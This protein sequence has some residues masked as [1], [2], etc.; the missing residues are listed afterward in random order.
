M[1][2][3]VSLFFTQVIFLSAMFAQVSYGTYQVAYC[4]TIL[5]DSTYQ[6]DQFGY[7]GPAPLF[8]HIWY[9]TKA[10]ADTAYLSIG[11]FTNKALPEGL[12]GVYEQLK[13]KED[14]I[15]IRDAIESD[16]LTGETNDFGDYTHAD[17][18]SLV[19]KLKTQSVQGETPVRLDFPA[20]VYHH[21]S[22]GISYENYTM[23]EFFASHGFVFISANF[24]LPYEGIQYGLQPYAIY[25]KCRTT[26]GG[27]R[28]VMRF[29]KDLC[30]DQKT[31]LI[32]H[33]WGA[34]EGWRLL[35]DDKLAD[36]FVSLETT[37]EYKQDT[38]QIKE[39]WPE[40]YHALDDKNKSMQIPVLVL[41]AK[42]EGLSFNVFRQTC[43]NH[44]TFASY[45]KPFD[46]NSYAAIYTNRY[47]LGNQIEMTDSSYLKAQLYGYDRHLELIL[48][49]LQNGSY[50]SF[51][52]QKEFRPHFEFH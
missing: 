20:I 22:Q 16:F 52:K 28:A 26:Q 43:S 33:S 39:M 25:E 36:T 31:S 23:A 3:I 2:T 41:A 9:P 1:K 13:I 32:G 5:F 47:L 49:F 40:L 19:K 27:L 29:A 24:H 30:P 44:C 38:N 7:L 34:Q 45:S 12:R 15:L 37:L 50:T 35:L 18:S 6:Y 21:G 4:D 48:A 8:V 46:H 51:D 42:D 14:E 11:D 17:L 10:Y